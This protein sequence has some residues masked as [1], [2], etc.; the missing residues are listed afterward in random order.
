[1]APVFSFV[2]VTASLVCAMAA[3]STR[4]LEGAAVSTS[5]TGLGKIYN[6]YAIRGACPDMNYSAH[7]AFATVNAAQFGSVK[8]GTSAC[9]KYV[10]VN[11]ADT[12]SKHYIYKIVD[13]CK[14]C[15][16]GEL[17]LSEP[18]IRELTNSSHARI[19]WEIINH[20]D[21]SE[22]SELVKA[23]SYNKKSKSTKKSVSKKS[24]HS[25]YRW[26]YRGRGTWFSDTF[27]SCGERF[28]QNDMIVALNEA[29]M[30]KMWGPRSKC[31][32]K[33]R[34]TARG[35][36]KSIV[37]RVVDTC[38]HRFCSYGQLDLSQ[39]AFK[40]FAHKDKGILDLRWKFI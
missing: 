8:D 34:V 11:H 26:R 1:M 4:N 22:N 23:F 18:A 6:D 30:G 2:L 14:H 3:P 10:K 37:V 7:D 16:N 5:Y 39:A 12:P 20:K 24:S 27:G 28:S 29:Q 36:S 33:I 40:H 35:S 21:T 19:D 13:Y 38:P 15:N 17:G 31:G 9:G 32:A 25:H